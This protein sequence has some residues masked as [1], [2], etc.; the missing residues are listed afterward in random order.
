MELNPQ[1]TEKLG[2]DCAETRLYNCGFCKKGFS[3]AQALG[4]H[5]N[6]HRRDR[7]KL[8]QLSSNSEEEKVLFQLY[9]GDEDKNY[10]TDLHKKDKK[11]E[12]IDLEL[13]L[14]LQPHQL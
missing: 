8:K 6:I 13:R 2:G 12:I 5:M 3:N 4:G 11:I 1:E 9:S 10:S 14:G 7:A